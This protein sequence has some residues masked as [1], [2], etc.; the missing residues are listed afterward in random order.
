M[1]KSTIVEEGVRVPMRDGACIV[2]D[3]HRPAS[4]GPHPAILM[5]SYGRRFGDRNPGLIRD[6]VDAGYAYLN[7]EVRGRGGSDGEWRPERAASVEGADGYDTIEWLAAQPWCDGNVGMIGASHM[8]AMQ[9]FAAMEHP[10]HLKAIAPWTGG[11]P[12]SGG[13]G[14]RPARSGGVVSFITTLVWIPNEVPGVLDNL[15][16]DGQDV[17]HARAMVARVRSDPAELYNHLPLLE[18]PLAREGRVGELFRWRVQTST[19]VDEQAPR[20]WSRIEVPCFH[21][22]GWYDAVNWAEF[23]NFHGL[24]EAAGNPGARAG[25]HIVCG[26]WPHGMQFQATL[27]DQYFG[28]S[29]TNQGSGL[30]ALQVAFFDRYVRGWSDVRLPRVRYFVMGANEWREADDWPPASVTGRRLYLHSAGGANSAAGDGGLDWTAPGTEELPDTF[31]YDPHRAVPTVGGAMIGAVTGPGILVGPVEQSRVERR[32][33]VL[34]YTSAPFSADTE[35]S[36]PLQAHLSVSTSAKDTD[37]TAKLTQVYPDGQSYNI[38]EG[39]LRLSGRQ[40]D[41]RAAPVT[42]SEVYDIVITL[43]HTS[44]MLRAGYRL[45]LQVSSSSFPQFD[46]NMNTGHPV[47]TDALGVRALQTVYHDAGHPSFIDVPIATTSY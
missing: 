19:L 21:E 29:A 18:H 45:R 2:M 46:R 4:G 17:S 6:L 9:Y 26:P 10:P 42:S 28:E 15:E 43:G 11:G 44:I 32:Y 12:G 13:S 27:G 5:R 35:L 38:G 24:R 33:D 47:G 1:P 37:F 20:D 23:E 8:A 39:I 40:L 7:S 34:C 16:R 14:F 41:G 22:C 3:V 25:Q 36:G 30:H 31:V